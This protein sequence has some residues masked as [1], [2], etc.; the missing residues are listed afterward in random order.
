MGNCNHRRYIPQLLD[1]VLTGVVDP[2]TF[3]SRQDEP[4]SAI[5]AYQTFDQREES[6]LKTVLTVS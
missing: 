3:I 4:T 2:T 1:H 6:W 5:E